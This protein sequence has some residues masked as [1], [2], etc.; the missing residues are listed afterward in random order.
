M[1]KKIRTVV[2]LRR[3]DWKGYEGTLFWQGLNYKHVY[4]SQNSSN[5]TI[6]LWQHINTYMSVPV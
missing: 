3:T 2:D 6:K 4:F 1:V 5:S